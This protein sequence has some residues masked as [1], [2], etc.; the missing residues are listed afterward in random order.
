MKLQNTLRI[1]R[2]NLTGGLAIALTILLGAIF[3]Q[4]QT[5]VFTV[6]LNN[7]SKVIVAGGSSLLVS[8]S[9][10][11]TPNS[12]RISLV[13]RTTGIR[14]TLIDGLPSGIGRAGGTPEV[15]GPSGIKLSGVKLYLTIS[16][17]DTSIQV[18]GG[19]IVNPAPSSPLLISILELTLPADY[20]TLGSGFTLS[21]A[22]QTTL[23]G[24]ATIILTNAESMQLKV[25]LVV[26]LPDYVSDPRPTLPENIRESNPYGIEISGGA[27]F[28]VDASFNL[29]YRVQIATG[30]F[31]VFTTFAYKPNPT[32]T[33][34]PFIEPVP[35]SIRLVG[36]NL[37]ISFLTGFPFV[38][39]LAEVRMINLNS[40]AQ[41]VFIPN[42]TSAL[43]VLPFNSTG[44]D[45]DSYLVMEFSSNMLA[46][47]PGRLKLFTS[48]SESPRILVNNLV[49]PTSIARDAQTGAIFVTE[50]A[51]GRI[52]RVNAPHAA[53]RDY[54]GTGKSNYVV[55]NA[56]G[57]NIRWD[58]LR[59]TT[60]TPAQTR[61]VAFGLPTDTPVY[62]DFDGDLRQD[63]AVWREGTTANPQSYFYFLRS[64]VSPNEFAAQPWGTIGDKPIAGDFDGDG[65][66]DFCVTR[67]VNNQIVW[68]ILPSGGGA[69]R[70]VTFGL[71]SDRENSTAADFNGDGRD[72][73]IVTRTDPNGLMTH[74][75]G[76]TNTGALLLAQ[77]WGNSSIAPAPV[78][79]GD[80]TGDS[81]ADIAVFYGACPTNPDCEIAGTWW[82]TPTGG[83]NYTVTKFGIPFNAQTGTGDR[84]N[85]GDF[86]GDGKFDIAVF[87]PS[88]STN[89]TLGSANG[90]LFAQFW[91]GTL[92][93]LAAANK[94]DDLPPN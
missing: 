36:N 73:L 43:D 61:R 78:L 85:F 74:Y 22:N 80:F 16:T 41:S 93:A 27:L 31:E 28:V 91:N 32:P 68:I 62:G 56:V 37:Y 69:V 81:R 40:R 3:S 51:T 9:G 17:G 54:F 10:T 23:N 8:E 42:L 12:G 86:D 66:T 92:T 89:N 60:G 52:I 21:F 45:N 63:I 47:A 26:N 38:P 87:R 33:G 18:T 5:S 88:D 94:P 29:L 58:I 7:P 2:E 6:G 15:S 65:K 25:R 44:G 24:G 49:T 1:T 79:F 4:A 90:Q 48:P 76:D 67:R 72:D 64:S 39:G 77:Q 19:A 53:F 75:A 82:I 11:T 35:D 14:Q 83:A 34:P 50:R 71:G 20:E 46:Q 30:A 59:N 13:N 84:P 57:S 55:N 70:Y